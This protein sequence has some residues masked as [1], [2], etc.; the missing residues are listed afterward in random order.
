MF[1]SVA[2][3]ISQTSAATS[4]K[5]REF[6]PLYAGVGRKGCS[7]PLCLLLWVRRSG[8]D[9]TALRLRGAIGVGLGFGLKGRVDLGEGSLILIDKSSGGM[10]Q[11][12]DTFG[13]IELGARYASVVQGQEYLIPTEGLITGGGEWSTPMIL[14]GRYLFGTGL[15][16]DPLW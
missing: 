14:C 7:D 13:W 6:K 1:F 12:C 9:W 11:P 8:I 2:R 15:D 10:C 16:D 3:F 5:K 4:A